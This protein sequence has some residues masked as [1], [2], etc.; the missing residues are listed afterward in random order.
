MCFIYRS[1]AVPGTIWLLTESSD[2]GLYG[3]VLGEG[4]NVYQDRY[5]SV[6]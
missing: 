3:N 1:R 6:Q 5:I 4:T 2:L